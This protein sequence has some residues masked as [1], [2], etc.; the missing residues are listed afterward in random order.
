LEIVSRKA[1]DF[2]N[3]QVSTFGKYCDELITKYKEGTKITAPKYPEL[4]GK[5][6]K[7]KYKLELPKS[8]KIS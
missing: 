2:N 1:T 4:N 7:G 3:I 6:L 5:V 8:N